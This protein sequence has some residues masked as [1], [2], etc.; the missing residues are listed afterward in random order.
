MPTNPNSRG[1]QRS[2]MKF[3]ALL[4]LI[5]LGVLAT[6]STLG[7]SSCGGTSTSNLVNRQGT[8]LFNA[9]LNP[10]VID[11][12]SSYS[13][14]DQVDLNL[15][16]YVGGLEPV[17]LVWGPP[18]GAANVTF[19]GI[20]PEP[21]GPPYTFR[22]VTPTQIDSGIHVSYQVSAAMTSQ[23]I[24]YDH[25][26]IE[27]GQNFTS[28]GMYHQIANQQPQLSASTLP[29]PPTEGA[30]PVVVDAWKVEHYS[31]VETQLT[32]PICQDLV[33]QAQSANIFFAWKLPVADA[34]LPNQPY[35]VPVI[36]ATG[37][38]PSASILTYGSGNV[39]L[40]L[41]LRDDA[42]TWAQDHLPAAAGE[43][44]VALGVPQDAEITC[45]TGLNVDFFSVMV[46][47][48]FD[49]TG[50]PDDCAGCALDYYGCY[51]TETLP[52]AL[53]SAALLAGLSPNA[54][55]ADG[56]TCLGND[57]LLATDETWLFEDFTESLVL[58]PL[59]QI[60][61]HYY[62]SNNSNTPIVLNLAPAPTL[63]GATWVI[64]PG[65]AGNPWQPDMGQVVGTQVTVPQ[66]NMFH[67]HIFSGVPAGTPADTYEYVLTLSGTGITP[68]SW[69]GSTLLVVNADATLPDPPPPDPAVGLGG[70]AGSP[71]VTPGAAITYT[72][73]IHNTGALDLTGLVLTDPIP[74][75]TT[76]QSCSGADAC[77]QAGGTVTWNLASLGIGQTASVSLA[78]QV[79][80]GVGTG[81]VISN[82]GYHVSTGQSVG[83]SGTTINVTVGSAGPHKIFIPVIRR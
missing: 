80:A 66:N 59:D 6:L 39:D 21:G 41:E 1:F 12:Q 10:Q 18:P 13:A 8:T 16:G 63:P 67:F 75:N 62:V 48:A 72:L 43:M 15:A 70:S 7:C 55:A 40:P 64:H 36:G 61:L 11:P 23:A 53:R 3:F 27:Q 81:T 65:Q 19:P 35:A 44:W 57:V 68:A 30:S 52:P 71:T 45:P 32:T 47:T 74:A 56:F 50:R 2:D 31:D 49:L 4:L 20:Q 46:N 38:L 42:S 26:R 73:L 29:I 37:A 83:A 54:V 5:C 58:K 82:A 34:F 25:V 79:N 78:V 77:A 24:F 51:R 76:Y 60:Y 22:G 14:G 69:R 9:H 33:A 17:N 28:V